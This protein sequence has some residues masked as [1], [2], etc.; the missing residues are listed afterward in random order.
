MLVNFQKSCG[1]LFSIECRRV[2]REEGLL[3]FSYHHSR[4]E[5]W[6]AVAKAVLEAGFSFVQ[7]QPVKSEMSVAAPKSQAKEPIDLDILLVCKKKT[8]D[9][10][11]KLD[12]NSTLAVA[13]SVTDDKGGSL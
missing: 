2:L 5:G 12:V 10:R 1:D 6:I 3:V 11:K 4:E 13:H 8:S 9:G 7:S